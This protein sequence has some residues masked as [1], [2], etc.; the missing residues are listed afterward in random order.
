M[1]RC[2]ESGVGFRQFVEGG[3][4]ESQILGFNALFL[5]EPNIRVEGDSPKG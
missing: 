2:A 5:Q 1:V 3:V 4:T